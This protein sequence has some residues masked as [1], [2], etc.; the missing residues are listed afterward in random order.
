M[1]IALGGTAALTVPAPPESF[2]QLVQW[3][4]RNVSGMVSTSNL[5]P[6][7]RQLPLKVVTGSSL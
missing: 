6:P 5:T 7:Q 2:L 4:T 1:R 3:Q